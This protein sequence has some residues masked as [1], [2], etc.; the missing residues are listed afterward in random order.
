MPNSAKP[1]FIHSGGKLVRC[2]AL[3]ARA[4]TLDAGARTHTGRDGNAPGATAASAPSTTSPIPYCTKA[5]GRWHTGYSPPFC[6]ALPVRPGVWRGRWGSI[7]VRAIGG[8]G[9]CA[10]RPCPTRCIANSQ[11]P[12]KPLISPRP[13]ATRVKRRRA[14]SSRGDAAHVGVVSNASP[15]G[16]TTTKTGPP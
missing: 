4:S 16:G 3:G 15:V 14:G 9:G 11:A 12:W 8:A 2:N 13:L 10:M 1:T 7:A 5:S 6:C